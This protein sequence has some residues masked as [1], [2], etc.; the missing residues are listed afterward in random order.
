MKIYYNNNIYYILNTNE[1]EHKMA[2]D[3]DLNIIL[4]I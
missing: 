1:I 4:E 2:Q 3:Y